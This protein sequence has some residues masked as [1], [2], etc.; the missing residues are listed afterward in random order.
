[1]RGFRPAGALVLCALALSLLAGCGTTFERGRVDEVG[2]LNAIVADDDAYVRA[3]VSAGAA[4]VNQRIPAPAYMEG[5]PL[6]TI[7]A[8]A[9][10]LNV[11]R[12]LLAAGADVNSRTPAGETALMLAAFFGEDG[13]PS[14]PRHEAAVRLLAAAGASVDN[15]IHNYTPLAYAAYQGRR[16]TLRFLLRAGARVNI[17]AEGGITHVNTPLMMAAIMGHTD[18]ALILLDAG[19]DP[20]VRMVGGHTARELAIKYDHSAL[21]RLLACAET[22][23]PGAALTERCR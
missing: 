5:T 15:E 14:S 10:S 3:A 20:R 12:L 18:C 11:L 6:L 17:N 9:A 21:A 4:G 7:A 8:R 16:D 2:L 13:E 22:L 19:A 1:M 23:P